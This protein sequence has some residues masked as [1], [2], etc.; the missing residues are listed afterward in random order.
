V[1]EEGFFSEII[2][3]TDI[4]KLLL[5]CIRSSHYNEEPIHVIMDGPPASAKSM[6]LLQ[7]QRKLEDVCFVDCTN[8]SGPGLQTQCGTKLSQRMLEIYCKWASYQKQLMM[9]IL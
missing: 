4:K 2:G 1:T 8:A 7:M 9:W 5:K 6:F 3:Y